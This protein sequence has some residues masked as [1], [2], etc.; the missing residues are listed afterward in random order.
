MVSPPV[1]N[2]PLNGGFLWLLSWLVNVPPPGHVPPPRNKGL[3]AGLIKGNRRL[4]SPDHKAIFLGGGYVARGGWLT[5]HDIMSLIWTD[6]WHMT[7]TFSAFSWG[8]GVP[9]CLL[10]GVVA[11][12]QACGPLK[13]PPLPWYS[14]CRYGRQSV[15]F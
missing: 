12:H 14:S 5:S 2:F 8:N 13:W 3:I 9:S 1:G 4:I 10:D 7:T 15:F 11:F 6:K